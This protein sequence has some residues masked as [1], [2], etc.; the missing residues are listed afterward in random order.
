MFP[1]TFVLW[2]D[3]KEVKYTLQPASVT[4]CSNS[5]FSSPPFSLSLC[6]CR[7]FGC[8]EGAFQVHHR[9]ARPDIHRNVW[10]LK[11]TTTIISSQP[12]KHQQQLQRKQL[13]QNERPEPLKF[14]TRS[15]V[16]IVANI[17]VKSYLH[18]QNAL[19]ILGG[20]SVYLPITETLP[21]LDYHCVFVSYT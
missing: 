9:R 1:L 19:F 15:H 13:S 2:A 17:I 3:Q 20:W 6:T 5:C 10:L 12:T 16:P 8:T 21:S 7:R 18:T 11:N 4:S 14:I